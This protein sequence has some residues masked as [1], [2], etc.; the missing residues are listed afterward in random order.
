MP[1]I[2]SAH[3]IKWKSEAPNHTNKMLVL[4]EHCRN[5]V[6]PLHAAHCRQDA[7]LGYPVEACA[8]PW[9]RR[10]QHGPR[11]SESRGP[12]V[13]SIQLGTKTLS[14]LRANGNE[15]SVDKKAEARRFKKLSPS[16][17]ARLHSQESR[18]CWTLRGTSGRPSSCRDK[19]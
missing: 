17:S 14:V 19:C 11:C 8:G 6:E 10:V 2:S 12:V 9:E 4:C 13:C 15:G 3:W 7:R 5:T 1:F 18:S 16:W